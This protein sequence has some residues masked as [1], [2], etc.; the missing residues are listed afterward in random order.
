MRL[1]YKKAIVTGGGGG[2]LAGLWPW[3]LLGKAPM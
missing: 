3:L 1:Q 2:V